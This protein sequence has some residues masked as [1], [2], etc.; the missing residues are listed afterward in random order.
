MSDLAV[1][2]AELYISRNCSAAADNESAPGPSY[3]MLEI[4]SAGIIGCIC[5]FFAPFG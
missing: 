1:M 3:I 5:L 2:L 4:Y